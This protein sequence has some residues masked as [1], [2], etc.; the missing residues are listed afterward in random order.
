MTAL[1]TSELPRLN[2]EVRPLFRPEVQRRLNA[3]L[4]A[5]VLARPLSHRILT[6]M[7]AL[8]G[9]ILVT[10]VCTVDYSRKAQA[11]GVLL[12]TSGLVKVVSPQAG[13]VSARYVHEGQRVTAGQALFA[14]SGDRDTPDQK[15]AKAAVSSLLRRRIDSYA[16]DVKQLTA[17]SRQRVASA[18]R[19]MEEQAE[20]ARRIEQQIAL[21]DRRVALAQEAADRFVELG[22]SNFVSQAL[23]QTKQA[24]LLDQEQRLGDLKRSLHTTRGDLAASQSDLQDSLL[25]SER[26]QAAA[27]RNMDS[28]AQDLAENEA[29]RELVVRSPRNGTVAGLAA[30]QGETITSTQSLATIVPEDFELEAELYVPTRAAGFLRP[31]M[32]VLLRYQA[33]SFQRFGQAGGTLREIS[34]VAMRPEELKLLRAGQATDSSPEALYRVRVKLDRQ[35]VMTHGTA[36]PLKAGEQ[37]DAS[38]VLETRRIYEW[39]L[40]PLHLLASRL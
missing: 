15:D 19:R 28:V 33:Y 27:Q 11:S 40:D 21:Q 36:Q 30:G 3:D 38:I 16:D 23:V 34:Q 20:E 24:E 1:K 35:V 4:G 13:L 29:R 18:R 22:R 17:Q 8:L 26:E 37:L 2:T 12:P 31:G 32:R 10:L 6:L 39:L 25:Q 14:V 7:F 9:A 5:I